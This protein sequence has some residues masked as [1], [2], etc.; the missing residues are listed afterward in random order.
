MIDGFGMNEWTV[1]GRVDYLKELKGEFACSVRVKGKAK[2][3]DLY[4]SQILDFGCL[5]QPQV[6][7]EAKKKGIKMN[8]N[9]TLSG[10]L[11]SWQKG[12]S[13]TPKIMFVADYVLEVC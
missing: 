9:V 10:H 3:D 7:E 5:M 6:Y 8:R 13:Y 1:S 4:T 12:S 2:R 11:E